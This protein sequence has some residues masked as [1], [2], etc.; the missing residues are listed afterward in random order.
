[1]TDNGKSPSLP[2]EFLSRM[3]TLLGE[4][5]KS[6]IRSFEHPASAG[7]RVNTLK[8]TSDEFRAIIPANLEPVPWCSAGFQILPTSKRDSTEFH[9]G[10]HPYHAAGLYYLQ[11]PSAMAVAELMDPQPSEK[12]LDLAAAPGGKATH[13]A[14]LMN[15]DGIFVVNE[16]HHRRVWDL[17]NNLERFGIRNAIITN[18][19]TERLAS[20]FGMYFDKVLV[21]AP[22][23][24]EG[25]FR[26][27]PN[28][29]EEWS[30]EQVKGCA[31][32]QLQILNAASALVKLGG[33]IIYST[34][35]FSP[36]ENEGVIAK[37]L[38]INQDFEL[39]TSKNIP[40]DFQGRPDWIKEDS[41]TDLRK[42]IRYWPHKCN[43][44]GHYIA[45]L[46]RVASKRSNEIDKC[47]HPNL[48]SILKRQFLSFCHDNLK[49][50]N[51]YDNLVLSSDSL[52]RIQ[53]ETPVLKGLRVVR[54]GWW[55][56]RFKKNRFEPSHAFALGLRINDS[57]KVIKLTTDSYPSYD[58]NTTD[59]YLRGES[60][61]VK[62]IVIDNQTIVIG[63]VDG[64]YL[65]T[66]DGYPL[67]WGKRVGNVVKNFYPKGL[68]RL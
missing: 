21:D 32:R 22:C 40:E 25:M 11:D 45:Q 33:Q 49:D 54:P 38:K 43:G 28:T 39:F 24:G 60:L 27:N 34:C 58:Q 48:P 10:R 44:E 3:Q 5:F 16:I 6:F 20:H 2:E 62:Q 52:Y 26:K 19:T 64:W 55:L 36:E 47:P 8:I 31:K 18:E 61:N 53:N 4:E 14:A 66:L 42:T 67:G 51:N 15:N 13:I 1:L 23:S 50:S 30:M 35:T 65:V 57:Q 37:F 12:I 56:G 59:I 68:R 41:Y 29:R 9:P 63:D 17:A 7:I 46:E